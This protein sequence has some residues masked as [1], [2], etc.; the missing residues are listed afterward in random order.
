M[1]NLIKTATEILANL[2][3][4]KGQFVSVKFQSNVSTAASFKHLVITKI[5]S[6]VVR[7]GIDFSNLGSVKDGIENGTRDE[8]GSLPWGEWISFPYIIGHKEKTYVRLYPSVNN[9]PNVSYFVDGSEVAKAEILQYLTPSSAKKMLEAKAPECFTLNTTNI[10]DM[11]D[12]A[13]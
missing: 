12:V 8:V 2:L 10:L 6:A 13:E 7:S 11:V 1:K 5:T 9:I 3:N 4:A